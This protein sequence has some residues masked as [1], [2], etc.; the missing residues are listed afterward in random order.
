MQNL[1]ISDATA[2]PLAKY[3]NHLEFN[4]YKVEENEDILLCTHP[5]K[6]SISIINKPGRGVIVRSFYWS[7]RQ[8]VEEIKILRLA[9]ELNADMYYM[10]AYLYQDE[11]ETEDGEEEV[12]NKFFLETFLE[13]EYDRSNFS[14]LLDNIEED[15]DTFLDHELA[16]AYMEE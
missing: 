1:N 14:L 9:N 16:Q 15:I 6:P 8:D 2:H 10:K 5:R 12:I 4:G 11:V 13:G 3:R 7:M